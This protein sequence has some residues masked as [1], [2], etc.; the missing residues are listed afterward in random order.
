MT[1]LT[2]RRARTWAALAP[3]AVLAAAVATAAPALAATPAG[4]PTRTAGAARLGAAPTGLPAIK[5]RA[6]AAIAARQAALAARASLIGTGSPNLTAADRQ[7]LQS[8]ISADQSGLKALGAKIAADTDATTAQADYKQIFSGYRIYA[9]AMPQVRLVRANDTV[10][11]VVLPKLQDA[12]TRLT[13]ALA[14]AGKSDQAATQ[15]ADL[16]SRIQSISGRTSGE[17][18]KLL[19]LTPAGW[20]AD[21][22]VLTAPRQALRDTRGDLSTA[23]ADIKA[24]EAVLKS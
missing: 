9:L 19:A 24:V 1:L 15:M 3:A 18:A 23:R 6:A 7:A 4:G 17:S 16:E 11:G 21:H 14:A 12:Q 8:L 22:T 5:A 20:N 10:S 2:S 13:K